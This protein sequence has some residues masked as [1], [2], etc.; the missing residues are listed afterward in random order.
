MKNNIEKVRVNNADGGLA[1]TAVFIDGQLQSIDDEPCIITFRCDGNADGHYWYKENKLHR[2]DGPAVI[3]W[4]SSGETISRWFND[5]KLHNARGPA[6]VAE[7]DDG[8]VSVQHY[9]NGVHIEDPE[10]V[11]ELNKYNDDP[12]M[13]EFTFNMVRS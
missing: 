7:L 11:A 10:T 6:V 2:E 3:V 4:L 13:Y 1:R 8:T 5:G 12:A 9:A